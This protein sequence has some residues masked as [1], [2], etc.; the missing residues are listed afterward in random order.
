MRLS[1]QVRAE[2]EAHEAAAAQAAERLAHVQRA[3]DE[4]A[5]NAAEAL[6]T[7]RARGDALLEQLETSRSQLETEQSMVSGR[8]I[9]EP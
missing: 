9:D 6:S 2:R 1:L 5:A 3:A 7:A 8:P 4:A